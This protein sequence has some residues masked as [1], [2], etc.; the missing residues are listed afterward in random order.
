MVFDNLTDNERG[1]RGTACRAPTITDID[2]NLW[3]RD[4]HLLLVFALF[5][6]IRHLADSIG[7]KEKNLCY[8]FIGVDLGGKRSCI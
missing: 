5:V 1:R 7:L 3:R 8:S 2:I 6:G 4:S